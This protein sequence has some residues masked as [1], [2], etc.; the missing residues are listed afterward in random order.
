MWSIGNSGFKNGKFYA[1]VKPTDKC[2]SDL[3][4]VIDG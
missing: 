2:A 1:R 3:S 4:K